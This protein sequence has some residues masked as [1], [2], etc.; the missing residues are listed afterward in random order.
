MPNDFDLT[1]FINGLAANNT[2]QRKTNIWKKTPQQQLREYSQRRAK[3]KAAEE[4]H[5]ANFPELYG[6]IIPNNDT[7]SELDYQA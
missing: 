3:A 4:E 6:P 5:K 2:Q 1:Q 7:G